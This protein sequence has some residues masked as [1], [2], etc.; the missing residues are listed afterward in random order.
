M[1]TA[2]MFEFGAWIR[3]LFEPDKVFAEQRPKAGTRIALLWTA[4]AGAIYFGAT[5][6]IT[7]N[8]SAAALL[9]VVGLVGTPIGFVIY[10]GI[11]YLFAKLLGGAGSFREQAYM[12]ALIGVPVTIVLVAINLLAV[13]SNPM[14]AIIAD[15]LTLAF[16]LYSFYV[17]VKMLRLVHG[18]GTSRA[19]LVAAFPVIVLVIVAVAGL[20]AGF[21]SVMHWHLA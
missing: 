13:L 9:V 14:V 6:L 7:G 2:G 17:Q 15:I 11:E 21:M 5:D 12:T 16:G 20:V 1:E 10:Q 3:V 18:F 8:T 19:T 4:V